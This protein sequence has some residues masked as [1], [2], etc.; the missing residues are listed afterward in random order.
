MIGIQSVFE[1]L[2][3]RLPQREESFNPSQVAFQVVSLVYLPDSQ[4]QPI[5]V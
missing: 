3:M 5:V 4:E 1:T 2:W